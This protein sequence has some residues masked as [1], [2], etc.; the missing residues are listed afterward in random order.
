M[1]K[2]SVVGLLQ[3][4]QRPEASVCYHIA[5]DVCHLHV[6]TRTHRWKVI[7]RERYVVHAC[8]VARLMSAESSEMDQ[9]VQLTLTCL[10]NGCRRCSVVKPPSQ[11]ESS[12]FKI[13][14]RRHVPSGVHCSTFLWLKSLMH[15]TY[16]SQAIRP[17]IA[18]NMSP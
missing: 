12:F 7:L 11:S 5:A 2:P 18:W 1:A 6:L 4:L 13:W 9:S 3:Q 16:Q 15:A 17:S 14:R 10:Y 8:S